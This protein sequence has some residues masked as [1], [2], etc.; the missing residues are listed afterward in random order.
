[1][2]YIWPISLEDHPEGTATLPIPPTLIPA[3]NDQ[4]PHRYWPRPSGVTS[5]AANDLLS[6][7]TTWSYCNGQG[8]LVVKRWPI[9]IR[10]CPKDLCIFHQ[11]DI[12][13]VKH[14]SNGNIC[15]KM[16]QPIFFQTTFLDERD[17]NGGN[18]K[19]WGLYFYCR[20]AIN[21]Q[22]RVDKVL[23]DQLY[24]VS[25]PC[26]LRQDTKYILWH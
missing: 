4:F 7:T 17:W 21:W 10:L 2:A 1:M 14:I 3:M 25:L 15:I 8:R 5:N 20:A 11:E 6:N 13:S 26:R 23:A 19:D 16:L 12:H 22:T 9:Q 24:T 18:E